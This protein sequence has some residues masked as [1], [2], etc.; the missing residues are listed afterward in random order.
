MPV[1]RA[2][3][4]GPAINP[5]GRGRLRISLVNRDIAQNSVRA[6]KG[7]QTN[8]NRR[9]TAGGSLRDHGQP[10]MNRTDWI[11]IRHTV[12]LPDNYCRQKSP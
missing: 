7:N 2:H 1:P 8:K 10:G 6:L 3:K 5:A 12:I 11:R 9:K 4:K